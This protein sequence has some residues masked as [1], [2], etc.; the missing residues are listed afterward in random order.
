MNRLL[1]IGGTHGNESIGVE[2]LK[3]VEAVLDRSTYN[4][5]WTVG[6][7]NALEAGVR[8]TDTDLNRSAPGSPSSPSYEERRAAEIIEL[9]KGYD[10]V[11]DIHGTVADCGLVTIIPYPTT[12]NIA[13]AKT[14]PLARN[15]I[16]YAEESAVSGPITQHT[17]C[18]AIEIECGP[19]DDSAVKEQLKVVLGKILLANT[20][21]P[22]TNSVEQEFYEVYGFEEGDWDESYQDFQPV[23]LGSEGF[24]P[25]LSSQY[26]GIVCYKMRKVKPED[27][28]L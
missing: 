12:E 23:T 28:T 9:S 11:I 16:W 27:A 3:E 21:S 25:F 7:P 10:A 20:D 8:F 6:N 17:K 22:E 26:E 18:P 4:Y 5:D 15:V 14:I 24:Y 1:F 2:A 19:K 13:L